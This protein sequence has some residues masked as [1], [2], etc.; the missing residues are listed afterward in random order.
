MA[1]QKVEFKGFDGGYRR[2]CWN[3]PTAM[4]KIGP[5][6]DGRGH[7]GALKGVDCFNRNVALCV[8]IRGGD[9]R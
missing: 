2:A 3:I 9:I 8:C 5:G 1:R 6:Q 7:H 4:H